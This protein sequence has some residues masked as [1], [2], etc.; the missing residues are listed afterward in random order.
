[1][2]PEI[3]NACE[4][5][6]GC[7]HCKAIAVS[8]IN[9]CFKQNSHENNEMTSAGD[10]I[11]RHTVPGSDV[12]VRV[13]EYSHR[14]ASATSIPHFTTSSHLTR[15]LVTTEYPVIVKNV[16]NTDTVDYLTIYK[17]LYEYFVRF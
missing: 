17:F 1:M 13:R 12:C 7:A 5:S 8:Y 11:A 14:S 9:V 3:T 10:V 2:V 16:A 15:L 6:E 4:S